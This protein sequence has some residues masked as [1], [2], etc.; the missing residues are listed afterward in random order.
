MFNKGVAGLKVIVFWGNTNEEMVGG[1]ETVMGI[2]VSPLT[3]AAQLPRGWLGDASVMGILVSLLTAAAQLPRGWLGDASV[4]GI[5]VSPLTAAAQLPRGLVLFCLDT[6]KYQKK[7]RQKK[8]SALQARLPGPLFCQAFARFL[9]F[10][11]SG[12]RSQHG[13]FLP[14]AD[15][16]REKAGKTAGQ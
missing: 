7:S 11:N 8:A 16:L 10:F 6:K 5:L 4:M 14:S 15:K 13:N 3:A 1:D 2:L 12:N 9:L